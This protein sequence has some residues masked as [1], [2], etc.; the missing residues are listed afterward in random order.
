[1]FKNSISETPMTTPEAE[2][3]FADKIYGDAFINDKTF[4]STLRCLLGNTALSSDGKS[5]SGR[6]GADE[7]L[8]FRIKSVSSRDGEDFV[9]E[10]DASSFPSQSLTLVN[11][12][13]QRQEDYERVFKKVEEEFCT[14]YPEYAYAPKPTIFYKKGFPCYCYIDES[15]KRS[16]V[17][18]NSVNTQKFHFLQTAIIAYLPWYFPKEV[19]IS[20]EEMELIDCLKNKDKTS[21][22]YIAACRPF[23]ARYDFRTAKIKKMLAGFETRYVRTELESLQNRIDEIG[24]YISDYIRGINE[25]R[26]DRDR[27]IAQSEG[28]LH[29]LDGGDEGHQMMDYFVSNKHVDIAELSDDSLVFVAR[30]ALEFFDEDKAETYINNKRS[31]LYSDGGSDY[32]KN[33][34]FDNLKRLWTAV[35]IDR[36]V[37]INMCAAYKLYMRGMA[38]GIKHYTF[39][40]DYADCFPNPHIDQYRC[41][42]S[43]ET[44]IEDFLKHLDYVGAIEQCMVSCRNL[45]FSDATVMRE[46]ME[47]I[48]GVGYPCNRNCFQFPDGRV[49]T[50]EGAAKRLAEESATKETTE[51]TEATETKVE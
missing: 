41:L 10:I 40:G 5:S 43:N 33:I 13:C 51:A 1:M 31:I 6:M 17:I 28:L 15:T 16:V 19:G 39:S 25:K 26:A 11:L 36:T 50:I 35:F 2:A 21:S 44:V 9:N 45:N 3:L 38:E 14:A 4:V 20:D 48:T 49:Y 18:V 32:T 29:K 42:G 12:N 30:G 46:F 24:S 27:L 47:R 8:V 22:D 37:Q 7:T 34:G 23:A